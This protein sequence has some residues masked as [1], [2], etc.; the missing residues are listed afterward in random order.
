MNSI[1]ALLAIVLPA[2]APVSSEP[3]FVPGHLESQPLTL[4]AATRQLPP[5]APTPVL[6]APPPPAKPV[7]RM[8][9][10]TPRANPDP[11]M[12]FTPK[13]G[14]DYKLRILCPAEMMPGR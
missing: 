9:I 10:I 8:R 6:F 1:S 14:I 11:H 13:P 4:V 5:V 3:T 12:A 7:P 2:S